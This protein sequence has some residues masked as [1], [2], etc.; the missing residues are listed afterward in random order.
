MRRVHPH[1]PTPPQV[2]CAVLFAVLLLNESAP[3][4]AGKGCPCRCEDVLPE[5]EG[6][7]VPFKGVEG[8]IQFVQGFEFPVLTIGFVSRGRATH[9]GKYEGVGSVE[10]NVLTGETDNA[11]I[12]LTAANGDQLRVDLIGVPLDEF[13]TCIYGEI[14][15][16]SGR[17]DGAAGCYHYLLVTEL[18]F[19]FLPNP[20]NEP[21][22]YVGAWQGTISTIGSN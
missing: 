5:C 2:I 13:T 7:G 11:Q 8:G 9:L 16:G 1:F 22:P 18:P 14:K 12:T 6:D 21:N 4:F 19:D 10:I 17:F 3:A 20:D 15:S